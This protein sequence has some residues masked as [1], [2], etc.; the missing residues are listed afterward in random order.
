MPLKNS[1]FEYGSNKLS[2]LLSVDVLRSKSVYWFK[3]CIFSYRVFPILSFEYTACCFFSYWYLDQEVWWDS[4]LMWGRIL[5]W[6]WHVLSSGSHN[7]WLIFVCFVITIS[8]HC[9][10]LIFFFFL[11]LEKWYI[12]II[13]LFRVYYFRILL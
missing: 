5:H 6:W 2:T 1:F 13:V 10:T 3:K 11:L 9:L 12:I 4:C 7:V 8:D